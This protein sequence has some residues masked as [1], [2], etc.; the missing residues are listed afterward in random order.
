[1]GASRWRTPRLPCSYRAYAGVLL[2]GIGRS[3]QG[4]RWSI[5]FTPVHMHTGC[6]TPLYPSFACAGIEAGFRFLGY[7]TG[8]KPPC[9]PPRQPLCEVTPLYL[10]F[11][12]GEQET[13]VPFVSGESIGG[14]RVE[15]I[16]KGERKW[17]AVSLCL[18][19]QDK[20]KRLFVSGDGTRVPFVMGA[21]LHVG[22][23]RPQPVPVPV[24]IRSH[25]RRRRAWR[26]R[27]LDQPD[28]GHCRRR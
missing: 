23:Q 28:G 9:I 26:P 10:P 27:A 4:N 7:A 22:R 16:R 20:A 2:T 5:S 25:I 8:A 14:T 12:R 18:A 11:V 24:P 17:R 6:R 3:D 21:S 19:R 1:M 15:A 13:P